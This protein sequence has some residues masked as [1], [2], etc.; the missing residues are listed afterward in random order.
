MGIRAEAAVL[1]GPALEIKGTIAPVTVLCLR[2]TDADAIEAEL[3]ARV[4]PAP[5]LFANAPVVIDVADVDGHAV[6]LGP[7]VELVRRCGLIRSTRS[8]G[9][10]VEAADR[11]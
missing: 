6:A 9:R 11:W 8:W 7:I 5:Q 10:C 4:E 2:A 3:R 1:G